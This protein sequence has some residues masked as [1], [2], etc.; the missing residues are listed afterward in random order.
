MLKRIY[1]RLM[2]WLSRRGLLRDPDDAHDS[3]APREVSP[4]EALAAAGMQRGTLLTVRERD[5]RADEDDP[6]LPPQTPPGATDAVCASAA[7]A[8]SCTA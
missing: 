7:T 3:N 8:T 6:G 1:A 5:D 4:A 2:K